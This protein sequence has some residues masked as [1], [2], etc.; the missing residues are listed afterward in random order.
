MKG[1]GP[2]GGREGRGEGK[3]GEEGGITG[4]KGGSEVGSGYLFERSVGDGGFSLSVVG[5]V[6]LL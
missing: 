5:S 4:M 6:S 1:V 2:V 3:E